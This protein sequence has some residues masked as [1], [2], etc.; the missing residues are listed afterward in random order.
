M[1]KPI[2]WIP[3]G[4]QYD[5]VLKQI[6]ELKV[7]YRYWRIYSLGIIARKLKIPKDVY[8]ADAERINILYS[9]DSTDSQFTEED[10]MAA[11]SSYDDPDYLSYRKVLLE[12]LLESA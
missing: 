3:E 11:I 2:N 8:V 1:T 9:F 10:L 4:E 12:K 7:G 5:A 6:E